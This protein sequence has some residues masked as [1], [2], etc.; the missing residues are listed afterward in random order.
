VGIGLLALVHIAGW[1]LW[2]DPMMRHFLEILGER[3]L[4]P[5]M[6][7]SWWDS[8]LA[9]A[10]IAPP[11]SEYVG[12]PPE[13]MM[14]LQ[15]N[16]R[17]LPAY[18]S[19]LTVFLLVCCSLRVTTARTMFIPLFAV[20]GVFLH[21]VYGRGESF[22]FSANYTWA[23]VISLG[24]LGRSVSPRSLGWIAPVLAGMMLV[25]NVVIWLNGLDWIVENDH[26]LPPT[27]PSGPSG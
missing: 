17:T 21:S 13:T 27:S 14:D 15:F 8:V 11:M 25:V 26:L 4:L 9:L 16:W 24:L 18:V 5:Y 12:T 1:Y 23:T 7:G 10:W 22:L 2:Q 6:V 20:F 19:G 3:R